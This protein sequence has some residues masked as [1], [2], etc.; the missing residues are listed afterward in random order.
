MF[1]I[2]C[3]DILREIRDY[4]AGIEDKL[5]DIKDECSEINSKLGDINGSGMYSISEI[6]DKFVDIESSVDS[7]SF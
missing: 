3:I 5:D 6:Y 2:E 1:D 4:L 7:L